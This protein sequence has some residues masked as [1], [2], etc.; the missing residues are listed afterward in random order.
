[1]KQQTHPLLL[2]PHKSICNLLTITSTHQKAPDSPHTSKLSSRTLQ[3]KS[4]GAESKK[5]KDARRR[6]SSHRRSNKLPQRNM[7]LLLH[8]RLT[9]STKPGL[10]PYTRYR[11]GVACAVGFLSGILALLFTSL[12]Q[13]TD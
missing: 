6:H 7:E 13:L 2:S 12:P 10:R 8:L 3:P 1:M 4:W 5:K 11:I 9:R